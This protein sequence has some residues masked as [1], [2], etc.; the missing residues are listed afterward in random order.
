MNVSSPIKPRRYL[1]A[2]GSPNCPNMKLDHLERVETDI[3]RVVKL[4][5]SEEQGYERRLEEQ[6]ELGSTTPIIKDAL[7]RWFSGDEA[8]ASD[9]IIVYYAG[10]GDAVGNFDSHY[11]FTVDSSKRNLSTTAIATHLLIQCFFEGAGNRPA[12]ILLILDVCYAGQGGD[13]LMAALSTKSQNVIKG[14]GF[15]VISSVDSHTQAGDGAFVDALEAVMDKNNC[16]WMHTQEKFLNPYN[17]THTINDHLKIECNKKREAILKAEVNCIKNSAPAQFIRNPKFKTPPAIIPNANES[18]DEYQ[19]IKETVN[20]IPNEQFRD[21]LSK[22]SEFVD[23]NKKRQDIN[24][25]AFYAWELIVEQ[26]GFATELFEDENLQKKKIWHLLHPLCKIAIQQSLS[27]H[28]LDNFFGLGEEDE[29]LI[30][31]NRGERGYERLLKMIIRFVLY[32]QSYLLSSPESQSRIIKLAE[33]KELDW[34]QFF[35]DIYLRHECNSIV[36]PTVILNLIQ[37]KFEGYIKCEIDQPIPQVWRFI[38]EPIKVRSEMNA[39]EIIDSINIAAG[40]CNNFIDFKWCMA[41][42][43]RVIPLFD[44]SESELKLFEQIPE[45]IKL[46]PQTVQSS[47]PQIQ[48]MLLQSLLTAFLHTRDKKYIQDYE[49]QFKNLSDNLFVSKRSHFQLE[50][51]CCLYICC[52]FQYKDISELSFGKMA[53]NGMNIINE[54]LFKNERIDMEDLPKLIYNSYG[55]VKIGSI[56]KFLFEYIDSLYKQYALPIIKSNHNNLRKFPALCRIHR[57]LQIRKVGDVIL[58]SLERCIEPEVKRLPSFYALSTQTFIYIPRNKNVDLIKKYIEKSFDADNYSIIRSA[59]DIASG[60]YTCYYYYEQDTN[61]KKTTVTEQIEHRE[62]IVFLLDYLAEATGINNKNHP[63]KFHWAYY[64][65]IKWNKRPIEQKFINELFNKGNNQKLDV[66]EFKN[67]NGAEF[68]NDM[69][70]IIKKYSSY[71][72][73]N[74][75]SIFAI[76]LDSDTLNPEIWN[77]IGTTISN[78]KKEGDIPALWQAVYCYSL[79]KCFS[80]GQK[81]YDQKY[82]YNYIHSMAIALKEGNYKPPHSY[83]IETVHYLGESQAALFSSKKDRIT[84]FFELL[85]QYWEQLEENTLCQ[86][87]SEKGNSQYPLGIKWICHELLR[88]EKFY[89]LRKD[90]DGY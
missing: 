58:T 61:I 66:P 62:Y 34:Q 50:Y 9:C 24:K 19:N 80:H 44:V 84:D 45:I 25:I 17:L 33:R 42:L 39:K 52:Q 3:D 51:A 32:N 4:F 23:P 69:D 56:Y 55:K 36:I 49:K 21:L 14:S 79:A 47:C 89:K 87:K 81:N 67:V 83:I 20:E 13:E 90:L 7:S 75:N 30:E 74:D 12:N 63:P 41:A 78:N 59:K 10:H 68:S 22:Y 8:K 28:E 64:A 60:L 86:L 31:Y 46:V 71:S 1:I 26:P 35:A 57:L 77:I 88:D 82:W 5:T 27:S 16:D 76:L 40:K 29:E 53:D 18:L 85:Q 6:I 37:S 43:H 15:W 73:N 72:G 11:L 38:V 70:Y 54:P 2:I 65:G 48:S